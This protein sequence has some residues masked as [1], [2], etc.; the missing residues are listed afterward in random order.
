LKRRLA[1]LAAAAS[2]LAAAPAVAPVLDGSRVAPATAQAKTC[3][4]GTHAVISGAEKCLARGE[5]CAR[6]QDRTYRHYG[7]RCVKRDARG[8]YHLT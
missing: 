1:I 3:S 6:A 4:R 2:V 7:F 8:S 5:Y